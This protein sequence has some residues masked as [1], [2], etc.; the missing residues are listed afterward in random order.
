V[1]YN[2]FDFIPLTYII[3]NIEPLKYFPE[4]GMLSVKVF[5]IGAAVAY[6]ELGSPGIPASMSH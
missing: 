6:K 2:L 1:N 3:N 5:C 4:A